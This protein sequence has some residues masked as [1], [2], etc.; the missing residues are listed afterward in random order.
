MKAGKS[1]QGIHTETK[2]IHPGRV[3]TKKSITNTYNTQATLASKAK[4]ILSSK[5][6]LKQN[7]RRHFEKK[8]KKQEDHKTKHKLH[9]DTKIT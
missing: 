5:A 3:K 9:R 8:N 2:S 4:F 7:T 6:K 1:I